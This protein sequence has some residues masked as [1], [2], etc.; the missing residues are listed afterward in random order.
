MRSR[1]W[2]RFAFAL[3]GATVAFLIPLEWLNSPLTEGSSLFWQDLPVDKLVHG[4]VLGA[5]MWLG[6][7]ALA[8]DPATT[9]SAG[10]ARWILVAGL[11]VYAGLIEVLQPLVSSRS[12]E[13]ADIGF[14]ALG[15]LLAL[16][17]WSVRR[18][19]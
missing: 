18:G 14:G 4:L 16:P 19:R 6:L 7:L 13:L 11:V 2:W 15:C 9:A 1:Y 12:S 5:L 3:F 10:R 17:I 8:A